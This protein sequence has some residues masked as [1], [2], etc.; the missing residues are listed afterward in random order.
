MSIHFMSRRLS[1]R[2]KDLVC[3]RQLA[4]CGYCGRVL[5]DAFEVDH[6][7]E[8]RSDD[9]EVNLVAACAL[10]HAIKSRHVRLGREWTHM[11]E[12]LTA[13]LARVQDRWRTGSEYADLPDW[14]RAR[15]RSSDARLYAL[16][17]CGDIAPLDIERYRYRPTLSPRRGN[18]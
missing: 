11:R 6:L 17:L 18:V 13:N 15:V 14:L 4:E 10:C 5:C 2:A 12:S 9:R 1:R 3:M 7:N 8:C 16:S